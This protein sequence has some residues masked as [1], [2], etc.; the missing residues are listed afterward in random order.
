MRKEISSGPEAIILSKEEIDDAER[1]LKAQEKAKSDDY[2]EISEE[3]ILEKKKKPTIKKCVNQYVSN[4]VD[5]YVATKDMTGRFGD[6]T[7]KLCIAVAKETFQKC[8]RDA[9]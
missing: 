3:D 8:L 9:M 4:R 5:C 1:W 6:E 7:R 2:I